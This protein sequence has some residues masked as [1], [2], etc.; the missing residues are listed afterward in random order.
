MVQSRHLPDKGSG[1]EEN[2]ESVTQDNRDSN[3]E[4]S[5]HRFNARSFLHHT[6]ISGAANGGIS[7][8]ADWPLRTQRTTGTR[9]ICSEGL[10]T[11]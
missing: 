1:A 9:H 11:T 8:S 3:R 5:E 6:E 10:K 2:G 7:C 4:P